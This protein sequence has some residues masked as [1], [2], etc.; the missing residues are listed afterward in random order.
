MAQFTT[1]LVQNWAISNVSCSTCAFPAMIS[2]ISAVKEKYCNVA[3]L[4]SLETVVEKNGV[5]SRSAYSLVLEI[6]FTRSSSADSFF[7]LLESTR[8]RFI[9]SSH[10]LEVQVVL[11]ITESLNIYSFNSTWANPICRCGRPS[12]SVNSSTFH[13]F[14]V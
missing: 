9:F 13:F 14:L 7:S 1:I 6:R 3:H 8:F 12:V 5:N 2:Q 11:R 4:F 10:Q